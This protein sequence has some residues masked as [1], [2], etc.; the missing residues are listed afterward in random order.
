M[1][2]SRLLTDSTSHEDAAIVRLPG[3]DT[4]LALVQTVDFFTP[5]INDPYAFGRI[6]AA[7]SLSD[8]YAMGG[9]PW[10]AMNILCFPQCDVPTETITAILQG[11]ADT[12]HEAEATLAGGHTLDDKEIKFGLSVTGIVHDGRYTTNTALHVGDQLIL[13][14]ALGT[15]ILGT[16]IKAAWEGQEEFEKIIIASSGR[17]NK[18]AASVIHAL[19]LVAATDVTGF[20]LGGHMIEMAE[21]SKV[22][23]TLYA[24][25]LPILPHTVDLANMGLVPAGSHANRLYRQSE[26]STDAAVSPV[27]IDIV[28]DPQ[29]SGGLVLAVPKKDLNTAMTLITDGGDIAAHIGEVVPATSSTRLYIKE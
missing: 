18:Y 4:S 16:A 10:C 17:L 1:A 24:S 5:I 6:A 21:A 13:T 3:Q 7:N 29:T 28:F 27:F 23:I 11:S 25:Q 14:K 15:G 19:G 9:T 22:A 20:G 12:L 2:K 8:V 26:T